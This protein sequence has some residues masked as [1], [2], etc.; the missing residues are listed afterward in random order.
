MDD[1]N[2]YDVVYSSGKDNNN[3]TYNFATMG[4][5]ISEFLKCN[6]KLIEKYKKITYNFNCE[7]EE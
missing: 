1:K 4:L 6:H 7:K 2:I 3:D 5:H